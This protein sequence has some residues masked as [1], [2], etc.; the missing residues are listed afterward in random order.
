[1]RRFGT[2]GDGCA[3]IHMH[4]DDDGRYQAAVAPS[5]R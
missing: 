5:R 1:M 2:V 4:I 3:K